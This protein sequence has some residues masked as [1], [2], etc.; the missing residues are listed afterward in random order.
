MSRRR[1]ERPR[2]RLRSSWT[3]TAALEETIAAMFDSSVFTDDARQNETTPVISSRCYL[4][5]G[6]YLERRQQ[7]GLVWAVKNRAIQLLTESE[8]RRILADEDTTAVRSSETTGPPVIT[9]HSGDIIRASLYRKETL[10]RKPFRE[11]ECYA[12]RNRRFP[13]LEHCAVRP[14]PIPSISWSISGS[15]AAPNIPSGPTPPRWVVFDQGQGT[16]LAGWL[17]PTYRNSRRP[18]TSARISN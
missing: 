6:A 7:R 3:S 18:H 2:E 5:S 4:L 12:R 10:S 15:T 9:N 16:R 13:D 14:R 17:S 1:T 11:R 8:A